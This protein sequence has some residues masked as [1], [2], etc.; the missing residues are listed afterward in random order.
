MAA[1]V[2][3]VGSFPEADA[4]AG[5][6]SHRVSDVRRAIEP[7]WAREAEK[8]LDGS[9]GEYGYRCWGRVER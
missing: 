8:K 3:V 9:C 1:P 4:E 2:W 5:V 6:A 7:T